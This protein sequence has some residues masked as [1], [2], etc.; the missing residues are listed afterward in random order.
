MVDLPGFTFPDLKIID[1][2]TDL[3]EENEEVILKVKCLREL[4]LSL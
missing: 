2:L 3:L 1:T 4:E